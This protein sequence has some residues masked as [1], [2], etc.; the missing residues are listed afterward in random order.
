M[1]KTS[2]LHAFADRETA[3]GA[4]FLSA[5]ASRAE[6]DLPLSTIS[7]LFSGPALSDAEADQAER[8]LRDGALT[9]AAHSTGPEST[10]LVPVPAPIFSRLS[11]IL[12]AVAERAPTVIGVD[13]L[14]HA[15]A[16]SLQFLL[17]FARRSAPARPLLVLTDCVRFGRP[18]AFAH[19]EL[20][21]RPAAR[22][23]RLKALTEEGVAAVL[24]EHYDP[25]TAARLA[26]ECWQ[27]SGGNPLLVRAMLE[28]QRAA[29][30]AR[31]ECLV[32]GDAF[33]QAV[34]TCLY[35]SGTTT[36]AESLAV[37]PAAA[38]AELHAELAGLDHGSIDPAREVLRATGLAGGGGFR[39]EAVSAAVLSG[40]RPEVR[41]ALYLRAA[42]LLHRAG[43]AAEIVAGRLVAADQAPTSWAVEVLRDAARR[44][45]DEGRVPDAIGRLRL[46][47]RECAD[48]TLRP[49][50]QLDLARAE[51]QVD[52]ATAARHLAGLGQA[53]REGSLPRDSAVTL[54]TWMLWLGRT[55]EALEV[56]VD[57]ARTTCAG[58]TVV[59]NRLRV[60]DWWL[61]Y[62]YPG[63]SAT[64]GPAALA[65]PDT[66]PADR[67][68]MIHQAEEV[69]RQAGLGF[70]DLTQIAVVAALVYADE[71]AEA[72]RW[73]D[74]LSHEVARRPPLANALVMVLR[75]LIHNRRGE[76]AAAVKC[77]ADCFDLI[78]P[79]GWGVFLGIPLAAAVEA[80]TATGQYEEAEQHL[81]VPLPDAV[82]GSPLV[83]PFLQA[84]GRYYLAADR[85]AAA[86][87]EFRACRDLMASWGLD[88]PSLVSWR[89][90]MAEAH[91]TL[92]EREEAAR[93][94]TE[95]LRA[96]PPGESRTRGMTL[97]VLAAALPAD[98][99]LRLLTDAVE[100]LERSGDRLELARALADLGTCHRLAGR[101]RRAAG[102]DQRARALVAESGAMRF[103]GVAAV[104]TEP[105]DLPVERATSDP[106]T[107][108]SEAERRV[109]ALAA[110]GFTNRQIARRLHVTVSTVE[111]HLTRVY[112]KLEIRR[113]T[114]LP[115]MLLDFPA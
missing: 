26:A 96:L 93:L 62:A 5:A 50:I 51:W 84:R 111:Q 25:A 99:R 11:A 78:P 24:A 72:E 32:F 74:S 107:G 83:L 95:Q 45:L 85:P 56:M 47:L 21:R 49:R 8:L 29:G 77:V 73:C 64:S 109:A 104:R 86:L 22:R 103:G 68:Q 36:P 18:H 65:V 66:G 3:R 19:T 17:Y 1:G 4:T 61:R 42:D 46:A 69:L 48:E 2:L 97:R 9:A 115:R 54:A 82:F 70:R 20:L 67:E 31:Q 79:R 102:L 58:P 80:L 87:A 71:L 33:R 38:S 37:L 27:A 43:T 6:R 30:P 90:D 94:A 113:R 88:L 100:L 41:T 89:I 44:A 112:R 60:P 105:A 55:D 7:Q 12:L 92:G 28:D 34:L 15:D 101:E 52:P 23:L 76:P 14:H 98:R 81:L 57:V 59:R 39:H 75:A 40:M 108:L 91:L 16:A 13:D 106:L 114:D 63:L 53:L 35:R 110:D 10:A